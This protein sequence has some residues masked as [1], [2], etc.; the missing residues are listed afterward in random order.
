[1]GKTR[2]IQGT[3]TEKNNNDAK[4]DLNLMKYEEDIP[5]KYQLANSS[6]ELLSKITLFHTVKFHVANNFIVAVL[7]TKYPM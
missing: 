7:P 6:A 2:L 3:A 1:L 4:N 5:L